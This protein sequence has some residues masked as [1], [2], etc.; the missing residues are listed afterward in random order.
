[1][2]SILVIYSSISLCLHVRACKF[3]DIVSVHMHNLS[4][5]FSGS[6]LACTAYIYYTVLSK[7]ATTSRLLV[8]QTNDITLLSKR[9]MVKRR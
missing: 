5:S 4:F 9:L 1:M 8:L 3:F 6:R 2:V 7:P